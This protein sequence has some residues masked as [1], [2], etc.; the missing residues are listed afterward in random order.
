MKFLATL[1]FY[2]IVGIGLKIGFM[3]TESLSLKAAVLPSAVH[4]QAVKLSHATKSGFKNLSSN[5]KGRL[6]S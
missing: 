2:V 4:L 5:L 6:S 3:V 1:A